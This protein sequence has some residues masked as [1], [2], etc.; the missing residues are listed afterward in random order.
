MDETM[1]SLKEEGNDVQSLPPR[2]GRQIRHSHSLSIDGSLNI[3]V[4]MPSGGTRGGEFEGFEMKKIMSNEKLAEIALVDPK[5][6]KRL[7]ND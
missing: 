6:A 4:T 1:A 5:R 2:G 7:V 3:K